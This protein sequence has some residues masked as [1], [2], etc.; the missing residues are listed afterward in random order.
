MVL[1]LQSG[2]ESPG[3][4]LKHS[5]VGPQSFKFRGSGIDLCQLLTFWHVH[6]KEKLALF[7]LIVAGGGVCPPGL[8]REREGGF[9]FLGSS[10]FLISPVKGLWFSNILWSASDGRYQS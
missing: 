10:C 9:V 6:R 3:G 5:L 2:L 1:K 8:Q 4:L 7:C